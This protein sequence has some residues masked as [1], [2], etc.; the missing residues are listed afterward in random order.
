MFGGIPSLNGITVP[1][2]LVLH[3][4]VYLTV[5]FMWNKTVCCLQVGNSAVLLYFCFYWIEFYNWLELSLLVPPT[6]RNCKLSCSHQSYC[7]HCSVI[8]IALLHLHSTVT[9]SLAQLT[10]ILLT[11]GWLAVFTF[12]C[13]TPYP[14]LGIL[15]SSSCA[16]HLTN[17]FR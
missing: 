2:S 9:V 10:D 15:C 3:V 1:L 6:W 7:N 14:E 13:T 12:C 5:F 11:V 17:Q 8:L 16:L 4:S